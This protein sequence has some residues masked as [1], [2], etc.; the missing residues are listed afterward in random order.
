MD[1]AIGIDRSEAREGDWIQ[2][3]SGRAFRPLDPRP[4]EI[5]IEDVAHALAMKCRYGGHTA[6]FYSVAEHCVLISEAVAPEHALWGLLHDAAEAYL[7]DVPKPVKP[8][9][10]GW[11]A[12][13]ARVMRAVCRRFGL[14]EQEPAEVKAADRAI[15]T[16][17]KLVLMKDGPAWGHLIDPLGVSIRAM[18][19]TDAKH[20]FLARFAEL[21]GQKEFIP[22]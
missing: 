21:T 18:D 16:D 3:F 19:P 7:A 5:D 2:T 8:L 1:Q 9:L 11:H 15:L 12:I 4:D 22:W 17:E 14:P 6:C 20:A 10:A 13:E